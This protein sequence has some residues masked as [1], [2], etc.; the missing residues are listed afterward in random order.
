MKSTESALQE[1]F[2]EMELNIQ[3]GFYTFLISLDF[4]NVFDRLPW[5]A[6]IRELQDLDLE[7]P[8]V[9]SVT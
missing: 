5:I 9:N 1:L 6:E 2:S 4:Q 7:I 8:H 3:E